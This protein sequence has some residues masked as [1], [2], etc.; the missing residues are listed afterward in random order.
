[1]LSSSDNCSYRRNAT[2]APDNSNLGMDTCLMEASL[3]FPTTN[4]HEIFPASSFNRMYAH[5][6][7]PVCDL[8]LKK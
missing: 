2:T 3:D 1:M 6:P 4:E 8:S 7:Y 5:A